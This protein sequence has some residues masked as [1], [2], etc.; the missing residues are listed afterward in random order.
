MSVVVH[1]QHI[2]DEKLKRESFRKQ[3][4]VEYKNNLIKLTPEQLEQER[5]KVDNN[6]YANATQRLVF[7]TQRELLQEVI[8]DNPFASYQR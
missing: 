7:E 5:Q 3:L 6:L 1:I 8:D 4:I 2:K